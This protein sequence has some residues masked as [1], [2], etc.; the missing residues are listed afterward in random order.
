MKKYRILILFIL[1]MFVGMIDVKA[2]NSFGASLTDIKSA[3][4]SKNISLSNNDQF[5]FYKTYINGSVVDQNDPKYVVLYFQHSSTNN[6]YYV[7]NYT[8]AFYS[9]FASTYPATSN[10]FM[11]EAN[12]FKEYSGKISGTNW[13]NPSTAQLYYEYTGSSVPIGCSKLKIYLE[14]D[15]H[16][17]FV[18]DNNHSYET[19]YTSQYTSMNDATKYN[20]VSEQDVIDALNKVEKTPEENQ[21]VCSINLST[22]GIATI[23]YTL[24][25]SKDYGWHLEGPGGYIGCFGE[26]D[27][28]N[29]PIWKG[30]DDITN[31][32]ETFNCT[33]YCVAQKVNNDYSFCTFFYVKKNNDG[34]CENISSDI[35]TGSHNAG[36]LVTNYVEYN[37][38]NAQSIS[39]FNENGTIT[40]EKGGTKLNVTNLSQYN[41]VFT[42]TG[43]VTYPKYLIKG[44]GSDVY[45][46]SDENTAESDAVYINSK[47]LNSFV[48]LGE[49]EQ[50]KTCED[51]LGTGEGDIITFLREHVFM[52]IWIGVPIIL[53][54][55]TSFDFAKVV[56]SDD[57]DGLKNAWKNFRRRALVSVLIFL[58]P[59][60]IIA[61]G[62]LINGGSTK[63]GDINSVLDCVR[64]IQ[65]MSDNAK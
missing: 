28:Y 38:S 8:A 25:Y 27:G 45:V 64:T 1:G 65:Q 18:F 2:G 20:G 33:D 7:S 19:I 52:V 14:P 22:K 31:F 42:S 15:S 53:I 50:Y 16:M 6:T 59:S 10:N 35:S 49:E 56:F 3:I 23:D 44:K 43:E 37:H 54:L 40:V 62:S 30:Y 32:R 46:F 41:S 47:Y 63:E 5:C 60:I 51:I 36:S 39:V 11:I 17:M 9:N 12:G 21:K 24:K 48:S 55:L 26:P 57:Q 29:T 13:Y 58:T 34:V 61:I 4:E